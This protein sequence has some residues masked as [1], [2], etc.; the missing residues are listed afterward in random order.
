MSQ[1]RR[2]SA[3]G[4]RLV[5][6]YIDKK[7]YFLIY[8]ERGP[9]T[10]EE[11]DINCRCLCLTKLRL[12]GEGREEGER[13]LSKTDS[14]ASRPPFLDCLLMGELG[15][16]APSNVLAAPTCVCLRADRRT[17][18]GWMPILHIYNDNAGSYIVVWL[19]PH[20]LISLYQ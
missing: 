4:P 3:I 12:S 15:M 19:L 10:A 7:Q 11:E 14:Y 5:E 20:P 18:S 8:P 17:T 13:V 16:D 9:F 6:R 1:K 2:W